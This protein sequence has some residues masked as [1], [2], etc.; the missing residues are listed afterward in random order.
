[1]EAAEIWGRAC[2]ATGITRSMGGRPR[3]PEWLHARKPKRD[4]LP[5][6]PA[7]GSTGDTQLVSREMTESVHTAT[8]PL[9]IYVF[10]ESYPN[11][12]K[13]YYDH[14]FADLL[15]K[16]HDLTIFAAGAESG[17]LNPKV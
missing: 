11:P 6:R 1:G 7:A 9:R 3:V 4:I 10:V 5:W 17:V 8:V 14:Q 2:T 15:R 12:Y 16:G 13:P